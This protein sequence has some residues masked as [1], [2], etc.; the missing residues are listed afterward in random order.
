MPSKRLN[1][2]IEKVGNWVATW[3][4]CEEFE[5]QLIGGGQRFTVNMGKRICSYNF[6]ELI[7]IPCKHVVV[8]MGKRGQNPKDFVSDWY[9][10]KNMKLVITLWHKLKN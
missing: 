9:S 2:E 5:V 3:G 10:R 8:A 4:I 7:G 6:W 1:I